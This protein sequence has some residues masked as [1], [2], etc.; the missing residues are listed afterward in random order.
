MLTK[1]LSSVELILILNLMSDIFAI[2]API[3]RIFQS[4]RQDK[5]ST[6]KSINNVHMI[7]I[8]KRKNSADNFNLIFN[9]TI[10]CLKK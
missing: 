7:L 10:N 4:K 6:S 1:S 5:F 3:S 2:T 8:E 9:N